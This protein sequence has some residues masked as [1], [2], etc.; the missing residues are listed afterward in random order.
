MHAQIDLL[1]RCAKRARKTAEVRDDGLA[2]TIGGLSVVEIMDDEDE[3]F[4]LSSLMEGKR[5]Y[6]LSI[7]KVCQFIGI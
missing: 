3:T 4:I 5:Y 1:A 6:G 7:G 2:I